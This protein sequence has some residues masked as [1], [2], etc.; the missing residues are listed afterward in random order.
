MR[1][2]QFTLL[3]M[4]QHEAMLSPESGFAALLVRHHLTVREYVCRAEIFNGFRVAA[5]LAFVP[6][7]LN[8]PF[9]LQALFPGDLIVLEY[10]DV[11]RPVNFGVTVQCFG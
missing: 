1:F 4:I 3:D 11:V 6:S 7:C 10:D 2:C 9:P 5:P 8:D